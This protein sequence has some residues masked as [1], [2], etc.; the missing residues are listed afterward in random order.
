MRRKL[1]RL[2]DNLY[3]SVVFMATFQFQHNHMVMFES[4]SEDS[5]VQAVY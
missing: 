3:Q 1:L 2:V 5:D 4:Q